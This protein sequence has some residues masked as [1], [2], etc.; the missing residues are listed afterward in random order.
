MVGSL[1]GCFGNL[2]TASLAP[3][4]PSDVA[5][6]ADVSVSP[7]CVVTLKNSEVTRV[8]ADLESAMFE[9]RVP[10]RIAVSNHIH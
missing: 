8:R 3:G 7:K 9:S 5:P 4:R 10:P 1:L 6:G 2:F